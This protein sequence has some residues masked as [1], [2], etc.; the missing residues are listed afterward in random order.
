M[1]R[2]L[3]LLALGLTLQAQTLPSEQAESLNGKKVEFPAAI[4]G[5]VSVVVFG[6]DRDSNDKITVWLESLT[7]DGVNAWTVA[8]LENVTLLARPAV[9]MNLRKGV[10]AALQSRSL[11][12]TKDL[13]AWKEALK[14]SREDLPVVALFDADGQVVWQRQGTFSEAIG[15]EL[16]AEI[17][18][19]AKK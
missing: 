7:A 10:P 1:A 3:A 9:R 15:N 8:N 19:L 18:K 11:I 12:V 16:K 14:V 2:L 13:K 4:R 6:F 17:V 5:A